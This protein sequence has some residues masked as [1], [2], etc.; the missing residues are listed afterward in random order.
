MPDCAR[1]CTRK[2]TSRYQGPFTVSVLKSPR[3][4]RHLGSR[5]GHVRR[6]GCGVKCRVEKCG[7]G[8]LNTLDGAN[9]AEV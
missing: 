9:I 8:G 6:G 4:G 7:G 3:T 1:D 5:R 2:H